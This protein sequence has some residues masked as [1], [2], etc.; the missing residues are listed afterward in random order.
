M[1]LV[2]KQNRREEALLGPSELA[3]PPH[4]LTAPP[5][6]PRCRYGMSVIEQTLYT[7]TFTAVYSFIAALATNQLMPAMAFLVRHPD[8]ALAVTAFGITSSA[9]QLCI[10]HT[11]K[12]H[13]A[14]V[15][16]LLMTTRQFFSVLVSSMVFGHALT[17]MQW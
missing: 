7:T 16:A 15:F 13:G 12:R 3:L 17:L 14:L 1:L 2:R 11:I 6:Q 10:S 9:I 8:A 4:M 5:L